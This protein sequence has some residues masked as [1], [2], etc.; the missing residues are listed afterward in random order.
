[1]GIRSG[2]L[3]KVAPCVSQKLGTIKGNAEGDS[4]TEH[5]LV[6]WGTL[7]GVSWEID[8]SRLL[9]KAA[10]LDRIC[11]LSNHQRD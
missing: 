7:P 1:M 3:L 10:E 8:A 5:Y 11:A 6:G 4:S 2:I 9:S